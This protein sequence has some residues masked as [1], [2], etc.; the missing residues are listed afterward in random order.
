MEQILY[1]DSD[2]CR[3]S[4]LHGLGHWYS[5]YPQ[6]IPEI[7][8]QFFSKHPNLRPELKQYGEQASIG[9]VL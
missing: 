8:A 2:A 9:C 7:I 4:A 3:E 1:L 5:A 6:E